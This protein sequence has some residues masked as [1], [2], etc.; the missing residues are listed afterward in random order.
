MDEKVVR[1]TLNQAG[2]PVPDQDP[3]PVKMNQQKVRFCADFDFS[4]RIDDYTDVSDVRGGS[5]CAY[6]VKTGIFSDEKRYKY[7]I[8]A[9]GKVTDPFLD[10]KP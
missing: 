5:D 9:N 6:E 7:D 3:V 1:I 4:I 8:I 10:I 2:F